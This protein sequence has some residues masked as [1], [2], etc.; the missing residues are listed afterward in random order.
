MTDT[1]TYEVLA[2]RYGTQ[3]ERT[4]A[5]NFLF[6][7]DHTAL[8][9]I[10]YYVWAIRGGGRTIVVDTGSAP[11]PP[12]GAGAPCRAAPPRASPWPASMRRPSRMS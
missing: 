12:P 7:D 5:S 1:P 9:P 6:P 10:D 8:M 3:Q 2:I 11:Q 4:A